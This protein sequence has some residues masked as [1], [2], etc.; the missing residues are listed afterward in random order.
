M[1][2]EA[3]LEGRESCARRGAFHQ[4][5]SKAKAVEFLA[6]AYAKRRNQWKFPL[7]G[8]KSTYI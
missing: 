6:H 5:I 3:C 8:S 1:L 2:I 7:S 4:Q